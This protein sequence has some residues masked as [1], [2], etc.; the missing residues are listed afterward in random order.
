MAANKIDTG[1]MYKENG[2]FRQY[3]D[4]YCNTY[5]V[6]AQEAITHAL[7]QEVAISYQENITNGET[8]ITTEFK[9][10]ENG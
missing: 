4:K 1:K 10:T 2:K 9:S 8:K 5:G 7:V 3:V 6:S